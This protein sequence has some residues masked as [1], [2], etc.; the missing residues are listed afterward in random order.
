MGKNMTFLSEKEGPYYYGDTS[1]TRLELE[2]CIHFHHGAFRN[3]WTIEEFAEIAL[4]FNEAYSK[5]REL[6]WPKQSE[7]MTLLSG[8]NIEESPLQKN[9]WAIEITSSNL[10]HL[11]IGNLRLRLKPLDFE[12]LA[13][14]FKEAIVEFYQYEKQTIDITGE[15]IVLP[16]HIEKI[17]IPLLK[18]YIQGKYTKV[19]PTEIGK[20][21]QEVKW[22]IRYPKHKDTVLE[23][24]VRPMDKDFCFQTGSVPR[25]LDTKYLFAIYESI[26]EWGYA[27]GPF[28]GE[29][30]SVL[31][32]GNEKLQITDAHRI[33][34]LLILGYKEIDAFVSKPRKDDF[35]WK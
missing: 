22:H 28:Y 31:D 12:W 21:R 35:R 34:A 20:L 17:Y 5:M 1:P 4:L 32:I 16:T 9:R 24:L 11:H 2:E 3:V 8:K 13:N 26:K 19:N 7:H 30:I 14:M 27:D 6:G 15:N 25:D 23:D 33:A 29:L 10:I 18:E